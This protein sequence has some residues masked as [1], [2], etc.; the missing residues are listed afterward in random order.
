M[1]RNI[2]RIVFNR[3]LGLFQVVAEI[4]RRDGRRTGQG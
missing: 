4:A 2:Y 3:T 1:N